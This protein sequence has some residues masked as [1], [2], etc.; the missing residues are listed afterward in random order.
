MNRIV[1]PM[2]VLG[3][4]VGCLICGFSAEQKSVAAK[5][6][7]QTKPKAEQTTDQE[8]ASAII[9]ELR[10]AVPDKSVSL[11]VLQPE[12]QE[13][14]IAEI[15]KLGGSVTFYD[16]NPLKPVYGVYL[17][18]A[19]VTDAAL[20]HL[21]GLTQLQILYLGGGNVTDAG[22]KHLKGLTQLQILD[23]DGYVTDAGLE[24]LKGLNQLQRLDLGGTD[25]TDA[26]L[27]HL[28]GLTQLNHLYL[29]DTRVSNEGVKKLKQ[30]L[31]KCTIRK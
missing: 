7:E 24:D 19:N 17:W 26:G 28:K 8:K 22:L 18:N 2:L 5:P 9:K 16:N 6:E 13:K 1:L 14:A 20:E 4:L 29:I 10:G 30:A 11:L 15:E 31:P 12:E 27:E 25:I 21:E 3:F 23:L